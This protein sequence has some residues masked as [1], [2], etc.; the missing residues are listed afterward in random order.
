LGLGVE[1]VE[2]QPG[3]GEQRAGGLGESGGHDAPPERS[4]CALPRQESEHVRL[5]TFV[6]AN[7]SPHRSHSRS[8]TL[9]TVA[10]TSST[11]RPCSAAYRAAPRSMPWRVTG[12]WS[13]MVALLL[14]VPARAADAAVEHALLAADGAAGDGRGHDAPPFAISSRTSAWH[15]WSSGHQHARSRPASAAR[16]RSTIGGRQVR[17]CAANMPVAIARS[18]TTTR[19]PFGAV[20]ESPT[21]N[22]LPHFDGRATTAAPSGFRQPF[23]RRSWIRFGALIAAPPAPRTRRSRARATPCPC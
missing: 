16:T 5:R 8:W 21:T 18:A 20:Q 1:S 15:G 10:R 22:G 7:V 11:V 23:V 17:T 2:V 14:L 9:R 3:A 13:A 6:V 19:P 4:R 12:V